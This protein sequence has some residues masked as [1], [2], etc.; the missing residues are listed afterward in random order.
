M[1]TI[2]EHPAVL[3]A[4]AVNDDNVMVTGADD[5]TLHFFDWESGYNF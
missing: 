2:A 3:N 1:R 4:I 5:G